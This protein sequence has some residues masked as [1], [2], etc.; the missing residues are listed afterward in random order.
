MSEPSGEA[1]DVGA[2]QQFAKSF[3]ASTSWSSVQPKVR[4]RII[5][6]VTA[7]VVAGG[8]AIGFGMLDKPSKT[9]KTSA[10]DAAQTTGISA[11]AAS[12]AVRESASA[13][14][15]ANASAGKSGQAATRPQTALAASSPVGQRL[16]VVRDRA[17]H[18][19]A[20][21]LSGAR[22]V[23]YA[24]QS[25]TGPLGWSAFQT[26]PGS[27]SD[28][29]SAP[30]A[31]A[32]QDGHLEIFARAANGQ[33]VDGWQTASGGWSWDGA[34]TG[35]A[36]PGTP[37]GDPGAILRADGIVAVFCRLSNGTVLTTAQAT[38]NGTAGWTDWT[39]LSGALAGN[40]VPFQDPDGDVDVFGRS[41]S[42][43]LV[44]DFEHGGAWA[45]WSAIGTSPNDLAYDP[46]P[47]ADADGLGE[48]FVTTRSG[49]VD[50]AWGNGGRTWSWQTPTASGAL[51]SAI[52][53]SP[54][55]VSWTDG[56]LEVF[57]RLADG[58]LAHTWE[59]QPNAITAWAAWGL[60]PGA[61]S[62][63]PAGFRNA[64]GVPEVLA[65]TTGSHI[66]LDYWLGAV[67]SSPAL[68][69]GTL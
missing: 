48:V 52:A 57:A 12:S 44:A 26:V 51:G 67:W 15:A 23:V 40:P 65:Y 13:T 47:A 7:V 38:A 18:A 66:E 19:Y 25:S 1:P 37:T 6:G 4:V 41:G 30:A 53:S 43:T 29:V 63:Y 34:V 31:V 54:S 8:A 68:I 28:V 14:A 46:A 10:V 2:R 45:G 32:D 16:A 62:G 36:L 24:S 49:T 22:T 9:P 56:H 35:G 20:F 39:S 5:A 50:S 21:A 64:D 69:G 60:L 33:I 61:P 3:G 59:N 11:A 17:G 55:P 27:P 42:G 58:R